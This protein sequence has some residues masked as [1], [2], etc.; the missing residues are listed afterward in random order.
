MLQELFSSSALLTPLYTRHYSVILIHATFFI[1]TVLDISIGYYVGS[2]IRKHAPSNRFVTFIEKKALRYKFL[3]KGTTRK[4]M[5][6]F[7]F[8]P[9]LFPVTA[10]FAPL[11]GFSF[12]ESLSLL[13]LGE[14][15]FW[16]APEWVLILGMH[17][18][19]GSH[20]WIISVVLIFVFWIYPHFK[21]KFSVRQ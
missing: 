21:D 7:I 19:L 8:G 12:Y 5:A 14:I 9:P 20:L 17:T 15:T 16:Y 2:Y 18:F 10:F 11:L 4:R 1:A 3:S 13:L 6:L